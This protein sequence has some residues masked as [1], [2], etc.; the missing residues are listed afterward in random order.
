MAHQIGEMFFYGK[1]PWHLLG[2]EL[3]Q[4]A[5]LEEALQAGG[6]NWEVATVPIVPAGE[7]E[8]LIHQRVAVVRTDRWPGEPGRVLG[9]VHPGFR[10]LQNRTGTEIFDMLLGGGKRVY[11]TGGYL[12]QGEVVWLLARLP[13]EIRVAGSDELEPYLLFTNSHDGSIAID[14]RLTTIRVVCQNTLSLAMSKSPAGKVFKQAHDGRI[15]QLRTE[16]S[17]FFAFA[18]QQCKDTETLFTHLAQRPCEEKAFADFLRKLL[19]DPALPMSAKNNLSVL[20]AYESRL[21]KARQSRLQL[22]EIYREGIPAQ[23][24]APAGA[25]WW[26]GLNAVT[27]WVDH[28]QIASG[29]RYANNLLGRGDQFKTAALQRIMA[30]AK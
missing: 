23:G 2:R 24:V 28:V 11:H 12:K 26:G 25:S 14:I 6:L 18:L 19:P 15:A 29:D 21:D 9:V 17:Q 8:T 7:P 27:A 16:A 1:R 3:S 20:H 4:P 10:P 30:M 5:N 13:T 22:L